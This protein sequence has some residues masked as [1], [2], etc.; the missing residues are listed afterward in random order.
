MFVAMNNFK[1]AAGREAE[2]ERIWRERQSY[3][4]GVPGF[5]QFA[6][7]RAE[8]AGEYISHS[9]WRDRDAF[10]AWTQSDAFVQGHRQGGSLMGVLEGP[11]QLRTYDAVIVET[12]EGRTVAT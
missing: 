12:P 8:A 11:P 6:L 4:E 7:L 10:V 3:L 5:V 1:V 9:T 2:F